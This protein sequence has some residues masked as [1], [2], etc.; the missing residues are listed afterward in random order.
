LGLPG[1]L[2]NQPTTV[3][4]IRAGENEKK[5]PPKISEVQRR[6]RQ[7]VSKNVSL[8]FMKKDSSFLK[9]IFVAIPRKE[10]KKKENVICAF[11]I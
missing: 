2:L 11:Y 9:F 1:T 4:W 5:A 6:A 8:I 10:E 7:R 3:K